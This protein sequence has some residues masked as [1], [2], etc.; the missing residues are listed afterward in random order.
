VKRPTLKLHTAPGPPAAVFFDL[1]D[2]L[3]D[4]V[5]TVRTALRAVRLRAPALRRISLDTLV[6]R[7]LALLEELYPQELAGRIT[8][9][10]SR[11]E[12][13]RR[14][15][16]EAGAEG[17]RAQA[18]ELSTYYRETYQRARKPT[19]GA[20]ELL[21]S[22]RADGIPVGVIS[23]NRES[24]QVDKLEFLGLAPLVDHLVTSE[25]TGYAKPDPRIFR[26][27]L[28]R[29]GVPPAEAR[30]VGDNWE[31]DV[32]GAASVGLPAVW[33]HR[34]DLPVPATPNVPHIRSLSPVTSARR[35]IAEWQGSYRPR[36]ARGV[37][38]R[39][40]KE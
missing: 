3:F 7:Y 1:D 37:A 23:N 13:F 28:R 36:A 2:T 10:D 21:R 16:L 31:S 39:R 14:L 20:V 35:R 30:M 32:L 5:G 15:L 11:Q 6:T 29:A 8:A 34:R 26:E 24:E 9:V 19:R 22:Y 27:A 33:F 25:A 17:N 4:H 12:R 38:R 18:A 40:P